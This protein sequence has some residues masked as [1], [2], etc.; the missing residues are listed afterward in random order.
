MAGF[1][2]WLYLFCRCVAG[3]LAIIVT[4]ILYVIVRIVTDVCKNKTYIGL[5]RG[6]H[7]MRTR[8]F[9]LLEDN[10]SGTNVTNTRPKSSTPWMTKELS[11]LCRLLCAVRAVL[12]RTSTVISYYLIY[13]L[14]IVEKLCCYAPMHET[15]R[16]RMYLLQSFRVWYASL[17]HPFVRKLS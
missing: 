12:V 17:L 8:S 1:L 3:Q 11:L 4:R 2:W 5:T 7:R 6:Y 13:D 14:P 15:W 16:I 9:L 10:S